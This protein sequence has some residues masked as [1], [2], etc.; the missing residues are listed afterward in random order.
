LSEVTLNNGVSATSVCEEGP[1]R[2]C[3]HCPHVQPD[4]ERAKIVRHLKEVRQKIDGADYAGSFASFRQALESLRKLGPFASTGPTVPKERDA[5]QRIRT[6]LDALFSLASASPYDDAA[7]EHFE[8][9]RTDAVALAG[10]TM[11]IAQEVFA[12]IKAR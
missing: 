10:A 1:D 6:V 3:L 11:S 5:N 4:A 7:V 2:I 9:T 12:R 8:P